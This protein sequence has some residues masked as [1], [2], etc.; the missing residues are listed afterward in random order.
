V[1]GEIDLGRVFDHEHASLYGCERSGDG[2]SD[3]V[4]VHVG[5]SE[6]AG[7]GDD[8]CAVV[9][10]SLDGSGL[11]GSDA[12]QEQIPLFARRSSPR[13]KWTAGSMTSGG[14][15]GRRS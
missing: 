10:K 13:S 15:V 6:E 12:P 8:G 11:V 14:A 2:V 5:I 4:E 3:R 9:G 7:G 1:S